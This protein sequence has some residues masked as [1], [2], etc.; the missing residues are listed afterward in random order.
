MRPRISDIAVRGLAAF[1]AIAENMGIFR[2]TQYLLPPS[3][4]RVSFLRAVGASGRTL[5]LFPTQTIEGMST[6]SNTTFH[7]DSICV[8]R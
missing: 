5:V 7:D 4:S 8:E 2:V 6:L 1:A 3:P